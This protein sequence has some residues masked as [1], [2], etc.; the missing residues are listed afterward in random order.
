M[1]IQTTR[2]DTDLTTQLLRK[3]L[4]IPNWFPDKRVDTMRLS[5][6]ITVIKR[7]IYSLQRSCEGYIFTPV[8]H[9]VYGG[10]SASVHAGIPHPPLG[11]GTP[12]RE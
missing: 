10:R 4:E 5:V 3:T 12:P 6:N 8:C 9:S 7:Y 2:R 1:S 11:T